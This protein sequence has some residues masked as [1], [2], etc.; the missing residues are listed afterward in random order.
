MSA[1]G[2]AA[3]AR[4]GAGRIAHA[5]RV[6]DRDQRLAAIAALGLF[7]TMLLP[8]YTKTDTVVIKGAPRSSQT[9]FTAFGAFSFVEAAVLLV[10]AGVLAMLF[11]RAEGRAFHLPG[12]DGT[13]TFVAGAWAAV[14]IFYRMVDK[15][16]LHGNDVISAT[17]GITWGIFIA[18][19][20][21]LAL[22][23]AGLRLRAAGRPEPPLVEPEERSN[24]PAPHE[25]DEP[26]TVAVGP[27]GAASGAG[28]RPT[29][30]EPEPASAPTAP[31]LRER[32]PP[33]PPPRDHSRRIVTREDAEQ[34]SFEDAPTE[35][36]WGGGEPPTRRRRG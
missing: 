6:L 34:L 19:L 4:S 12:G 8:W 1:H 13:I 17:E 16:A 35:E 2:A 21:A 7:V 32:Y 15:P 22:A 20:V 36:P 9:T 26:E 18:L 27:V 3:R 33:A 5:W 14:L 11:A 31:P 24:G 29:S 28:R 30:P 23:Y 25:D 10:S